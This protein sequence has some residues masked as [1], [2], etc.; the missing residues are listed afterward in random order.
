MRT[1]RIKLALQLLF[2]GDPFLEDRP[3]QSGKLQLG[4]VQPR[5]IF[6]EHPVKLLAHRI[7][8]AGDPRLLEKLRREELIPLGSRI[9]TR[10]ATEFASRDELLACLEHLM[11]PGWQCESDD[12]ARRM[13]TIRVRS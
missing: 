4:D 13:A 12:K 1:D 7:V 11:M 10:L 6:G 9:R 2:I 3:P 5:P 8:L